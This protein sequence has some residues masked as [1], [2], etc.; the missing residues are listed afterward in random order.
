[1]QNT[2][3]NTKLSTASE[4]GS[5][6]IIGL[7][8]GV[9]S[10]KSTVAGYFA[11]L[12]VPV[13]DTDIIARKLVEP[14]QPGLQQIV[15]CFGEQFLN[16][17]STLNRARLR[18]RVF[19]NPSERYKLEQLLHPLIRAEMQRQRQQLDAPYC[20]LEIPLL[21]ESGWTGDVNRILVVDAPRTLQIERTL[22]RDGISREQVEQ[23]IAAQAQRS[24][25]LA[26][27][28][29]VITNE[30]SLS[31]LRQQVERLHRFYLQKTEK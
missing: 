10:G 31:Q 27:A 17:D 13:I 16:G 4:P 22:Q 15:D 9:G 24:Q 3:D 11:D 6:L 21:L 26:T 20:I 7:T 29:D 8:G 30:G 2:T 23:I 25:R 28:D 14:G 12:D 1:M 18:D 19:A 5:P